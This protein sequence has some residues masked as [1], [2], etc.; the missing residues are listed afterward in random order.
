[1][2]Q[3]LSP[4]ASTSLRFFSDT[5]AHTP[6]CQLPF[7]TTGSGQLCFIRG[8]PTA[9]WLKLIG[10]H[11]RIDPEFF[12]RHLDFLQVK[13]HYDLPPL[14]SN[15][16]NMIRLRVCDIFHR[17]AALTPQQFRNARQEEKD[18]LQRFQRHLL[19]RGIAGDSLIRRF[20]VHN[21][22]TF[23]VEYS[24]SIYVTGSNKRGWTG[25]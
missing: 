9:E 21:Q 13:K 8:L 14:P 4:H 16:N 23:T 6:T 19:N 25:Q 17:Q 1:V 18:R 10:A 5:T 3:S 12:R 24:I 20:S 2:A 22:T 15:A 7:P 11:Y